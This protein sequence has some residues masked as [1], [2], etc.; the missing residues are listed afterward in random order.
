M[1][2]SANPVLAALNDHV[3]RALVMTG[4]E[5]L[6]VLTPWRHRVR[7]T[8]ARLT[9]TTTVRVIDR[10]HRKTAHRRTNTEPA[11]RAGLAVAAQVVL[12]VSNFAKGRAAVDVH[13]ARLARL[14]TQVGVNA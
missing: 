5:A 11:L 7:I 13:L 6:G 4:L 2:R 8:L 14:Q 10:V 9:L 12:V 3:V 1:L